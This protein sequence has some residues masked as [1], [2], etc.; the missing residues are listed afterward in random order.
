MISYL[1]S[2]LDEENNINAHFLEGTEL[3]NDFLKVHHF[4]PEG[5]IYFRQCIVSFVT[6][7]C[8]LKTGESIGFYVDSAEP[9]FRFKLEANAQGQ[10]RALLLPEDFGQIPSRITGVARLVKI[11]DQAKAPYTS[12]IDLKN[13]TFTEVIN[14]FLSQSYQVESSLHL[15]PSGD[16]ALLLNKVPY[17]I[18][19]VKP[20][21]LQ[22]FWQQRQES[23]LSL[24]SAQLYNLDKIQEAFRQ[25]GFV[26]LGPRKMQF[27]CN[28]SQQR[29]LDNLRLLKATE[30]GN[31]FE[32]DKDTLECRCDYCK[33]TYLINRQE[34]DA[35]IN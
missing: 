4:P 1:Y 25:L 35:V 2:F 20:V 5:E 6:T 16:Q 14:K 29:M 15:S 27:K 30:K 7:L 8:F 32:L 28:C 12:I 11:I 22:E 34:L 31:L 10:M 23:V 26:Y 17:K 24:F 19:K 21:N 33:T 18:L 9:Y 3:I 13:N